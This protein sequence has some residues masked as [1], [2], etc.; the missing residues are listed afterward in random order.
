[1][2]REKHYGGTM[3]LGNYKCRLKNNTKASLAYK[4]QKVIV[5]R[6]RHRYEVNNKYREK[7]EKKG[8]IMSGINPKRDLVEIIEL[9]DHPFFVSTQFHPEF[10]TRPLR[11]H[12][13]FKEFIKAAIKKK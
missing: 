11:P 5:E 1:L 2:L 8:M 6:H 7:L 3:R 10:K 4:G 12:P 13:L 9:S